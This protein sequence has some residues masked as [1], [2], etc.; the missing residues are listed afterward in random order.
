MSVV[1]RGAKNAFRNTVRTLAVVLILA[2]SIGLALIML[3]SSRTVESRIETVKSSIGNSIT[4]SPA[5]ARGFEGGG[6]P[7][8]TTDL[9]TIKG[10]AH[11]STVTAT[12]ADRLVPATDTNL[13]SAID[14]GT[15]GT[16]QAR[17][18]GGGGRG[19]EA[20]GSLSSTPPVI[21]I[22]VTG[23]TDTAV[24][25]SNNAKLTAGAEFDPSTD[26]T[27]AVVGSALATKN[28]LS[29]GSTF[30]TYGETATVVGIVDIGNE[31][32][33]SGIYMPIKP[34]QRLSQ[35]TDQ[36]STLSVQADTI[37][38]VDPVVAAIKSSLGT[39]A[40]VESNQAQATQALT[41]LENIKTISL[42]SLIGALAAGAIITLLTM[43][44][45]VRERRREIGVLKAIGASNA[46]VVTQFM[47][48]SLVLTLLGGAVG[49]VLGIAFS[50]PVLKALVSSNTGQAATQGAQTVMRTGGPGGAG[51]LIARFGGQVGGQ[52]A[53]LQNSIRDIHAVVGIDVLLY[54]LA[55][56]ILIAVIGS[57]I[58]A[59]LIANVRP[60]E[61]M[62]GE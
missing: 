30:T 1:I 5:G 45:I 14:P 36:V 18:F 43:I 9:N 35:Q 52:V 46:T 6:E 40:D 49:T 38:D 41:P 56:A 2:I 32:A 24:L 3:L 59:W 28:N 62:R 4:V 7:L 58:P 16:R 23:L 27:V 21:P 48:E 15:L 53:G 57:A 51:G 31:F 19:G 8:T 12:L 42:Y 55:A 60:A 25:H 11:V 10:L 26:K 29:V 47:A 33:N 37:T 61:V 17:R 20:G 50:N 44:M 54:G 13:V 34:V 39:R 22:Q